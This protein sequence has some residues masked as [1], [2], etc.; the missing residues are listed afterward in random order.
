MT[1][2]ID[3]LRPSPSAAPVLPSNLK[4]PAALQPSASSDEPVIDLR[5]GAHAQPQP[6]QFSPQLDPNDAPKPVF[7][8]NVSPSLQRATQIYFQEKDAG[9]AKPGQL[10]VIKPDPMATKPGEPEPQTQ[11][12]VL[13]RTLMANGQQPLRDQNI[14]LTEFEKKI[15]GDRSYEPQYD[16][17]GDTKGYRRTHNGDTTY[18]QA[19]GKVT[20]SIHRNSGYT[21]VRDGN[22]KRLASGEIPLE[23]PL[24]DP[25]DFIPTPGAVASIGSRLAAR[26]AVGIAAKTTLKIG[27]TEAAE[28]G[29]NAATKLAAR[30]TSEVAVSAA[31]KPIG[32]LRPKIVP[33]NLPVGTPQLMGGKYALIEGAKNTGQHIPQPKMI[34]QPARSLDH[35]SA[36]HA[37]LSGKPY[38]MDFA[39]SAV[40]D[41]AGKA[42]TDLE[43][44]A[45]FRGHGS[46]FGFTNMSTSDA[47]KMTAKEIAAFNKS[48]PAG[49][50]IDHLVLDS[51]DQGGRRMLVAGSTNAQVFQKELDL[52][53]KAEGYA[54]NVTVHGAHKPGS[55][56]GMNMDAQG[57]VPAIFIPAAQQNPELYMSQLEKAGQW[58]KL[59]GTPAALGGFTY[60]TYKVTEALVEPKQQPG[61]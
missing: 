52:A 14:P 30:E 12:H 18:Y 22:G 42:V 40:Y 32:L 7:F 37:K 50:T 20:G 31:S 55:L 16:A 45:I 33:S 60:G 1:P 53:L 25:I 10:V 58:G 23:K 35:N 43:K 38:A 34:F 47:A 57:K 39:N 46:T 4:L 41:T 3:R 2:P 54:G 44:V 29:V 27:A 21:E 24:L 49:K 17:N 36:F 26:S 59:I 48:A 6:N 11:L 5:P 13:N 8:G 61:K 51:C 56:Y 19:D 15:Q 9:R 28:V